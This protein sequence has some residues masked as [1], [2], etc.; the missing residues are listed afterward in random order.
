MPEMLDSTIATSRASPV[1]AE[2]EKA[3]MG[4]SPLRTI[5]YNPMNPKD[6]TPRIIPLHRPTL[7]S[8]PMRVTFCLVVSCSS[9]ST[10]MV[11][12]RDWVPTLP[13][14]SRIRDWNRITTVRL[15]TTVSNRPTTLETSRPRPSRTISQGRRLLILFFRGSFR[16]SSAVKPANLA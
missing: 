6:R 7:A 12:A 4:C 10:R 1:Q 11:T 15:A 2:T 8:L 5:R 3:I 16:S 9:I 14:M 13:A